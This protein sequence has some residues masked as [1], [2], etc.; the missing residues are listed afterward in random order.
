VPLVE[1]LHR[2]LGDQNF[3]VKYGKGG[4]PRAIKLLGGPQAARRTTGAHQHRGDVSAGCT[5]AGGFRRAAGT[6][7]GRSRCW[8]AIGPSPCRVSWPR[9]SAPT[10]RLSASS[11]MPPRAMRMLPCVPRPWV[12]S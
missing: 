5:R 9:L 6:Q 1:A 4:R 2:L 10:P 11:S 7:G 3:V 8:T 12:R